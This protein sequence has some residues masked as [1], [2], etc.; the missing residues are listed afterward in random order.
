MRCFHAS[1]ILVFIGL[2]GCPPGNSASIREPEALGEIPDDLPL[3]PR[4]Y[5]DP[6]H[7]SK[8]E[9][10]GGGAGAVLH[11]LAA[12]DLHEIRG[13]F[14]THL[15]FARW[16]T[17]PDGA[18]DRDTLRFHKGDDDLTIQLDQDGEQTCITVL[19]NRGK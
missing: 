18:T 5:L 6:D 11:L 16:K 10:G 2:S 17:S 14:S 12:Y 3:P 4:S 19:L 13:Y 9:S 8:L 7:D 1:I 15:G